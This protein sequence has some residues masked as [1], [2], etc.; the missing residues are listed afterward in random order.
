MLKVGMNEMLDVNGTNLEL[1]YVEV[2]SSKRYGRV[3]FSYLFFL[4]IYCC[5]ALYH[6][7]DKL[8][9]NH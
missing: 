9:L 3:S 2:D 7:F 8:N 1:E 4:H 6:Q 5:F